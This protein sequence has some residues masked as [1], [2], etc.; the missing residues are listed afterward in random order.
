LDYQFAGG[1]HGGTIQT[2]FTFDLQTGEQ[3][4]LQDFFT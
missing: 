4:K 1:A 3:F 2:A